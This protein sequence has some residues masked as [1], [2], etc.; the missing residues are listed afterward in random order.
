[1][2]AESVWVYLQ[3]DPADLESLFAYANVHD[4]ER[5]GR[6]DVRSPSVLNIWTHTWSNR[7]CRAESCLMCSLE[8]DLNTA[9]LW[10][11]VLH[12]GYDWQVFCDELA[13]LEI[14][15]LGKTIWG[16]LGVERI[17]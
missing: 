8:F 9:S 16:E 14:A 17:A 15:A 2:V 4:V 3:Y 7:G 12:P 1:M 5:S 10:L 11:A 13:R 6:Y